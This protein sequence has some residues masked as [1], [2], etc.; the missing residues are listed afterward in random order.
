M[1]YNNAIPG[2][3]DELSQS[4]SD[5]QGNF[6]AIQ[7]LI[8]V[9]HVDF[10]NAK[11]GKHQAIHYV[12]QAVLPTTLGSEM[13]IFCAPGTA[14]G[15]SLYVQQQNKVAG[16]NAVEFTK[17]ITGA[18]PSNGYTILPSGVILQWGTLAVASP[19]AFVNFTTAAGCIA[20]P[21][22]CFSLQ[23][24]NLV[25]AFTNGI[26][27]VVTGTLTRFGA[28]IKCQRSDNAGTTATNVF[29]FAIGN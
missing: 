27:G 18:T 8:D 5:I 28:Q 26:L 2:P 22:Q 1:A 13:S 20:F 25:T 16:A 19:V 6:A 3:N 7:T 11:A 12:S 10:A 17:A 29:F 15:F 21:T 24:T 23:V 14:G 9:D 4:Q